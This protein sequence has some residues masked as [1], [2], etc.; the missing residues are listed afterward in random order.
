MNE[1]RGPSLDEVMVRRAYKSCP[2]VSH[3]EIDKCIR[4]DGGRNYVC[5]RDLCAVEKER[6]KEIVEEALHKAA[7]PDLL[8]EGD[9]VEV[10][11][12]NIPDKD[13]NPYWDTGY[14]QTIIYRKTEPTSTLDKTNA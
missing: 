11:W 13:T 3:A 9:L 14:F 5:F 7:H 1:E 6:A 12:I 10:K 8:E 4:I 2:P